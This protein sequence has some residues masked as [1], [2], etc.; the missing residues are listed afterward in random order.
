MASTKYPSRDSGSGGLGPL[1]ELPASLPAS[2]AYVAGPDL[3]FEFASDR[4]RQVLGGRDV[5]GLPF[6]EALPEV[7]G[8][9]PLEGLR[10][11]LQ[12]G[13]PRQA[14][15]EELWLRRHGTELEQAY[16]D[17]A[18]QPLRDEAGRVAG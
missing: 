7:V 2:L 10:Q 18:Y 4:Y 14:C 9:P 16:I 5:I 11:V 13:E 15:G 1:L 3:V 8:P 12:S 6:R 17:S